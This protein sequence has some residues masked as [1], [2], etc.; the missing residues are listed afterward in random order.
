MSGAPNHTPVDVGHFLIGPGRREFSRL[1]TRRPLMPFSLAALIRAAA[2][3]GYLTCIFALT[4]FALSMIFLALR[5]W[6]SGQW[7]WGY[8]LAALLP[9]VEVI[10]Q[11]VN[12]LY[13]HAL[14]PRALP[15]Y[16]LKGIVPSEMRTLVVMPVMLTTPSEIE[17]HV[18]RLEAHYL[19]SA[20]G[21]LYFALLSDFADAASE[22]TSA[23]A[24]LI[25]AAAAGIGE[26]NRRYEAGSAGP[27]FFMLHRR[28]QWSDDQGRWIGWER[29]RGP[30]LPTRWRWTWSDCDVSMRRS[31]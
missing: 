28:R 29:K 27:R 16:D 15:A 4:G 5:S 21:E 17:A 18:A 13:T 2:L 12:F 19:A 6:M 30:S 23:D 24:S 1:L 10:T 25:A 8:L 20:R 22:H 14:P 26:L 3:L 11:I 31:P 9:C 7:L